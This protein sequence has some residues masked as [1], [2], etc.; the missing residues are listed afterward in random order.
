[1]T[2]SETA[3][4]CP[5]RTVIL[6]PMF[7]D[8]ESAQLLLNGLDLALTGSAMPAEVLFIDDGSTLPMPENFARGHFTN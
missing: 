6:I 7:N 4:A 1:M 8:W 5:E 2:P 3:S